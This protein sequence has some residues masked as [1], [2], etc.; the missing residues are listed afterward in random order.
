MI[1][2]GFISFMNYCCQCGSPVSARI[3]EGDD[4]PR[5]I[6][7]RCDT[8]HYQNP[9]MVVG[10]IPEWEDKIL[11]CKRS[12]EP[13]SGKWTLPAG[14]LEN[15]ET[16]VEGAKRETLEEAGARVEGL[17]PYALMSI[18][19]ISQIYLIF[20]AR[21]VDTNFAPGKESLE[22]RLYPESKIPWD[23]LAFLVVRETL[24]RYFNDRPAGAFPVQIG[25]IARP[26]NN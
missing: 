25:N 9:K 11:L 10:C 22:V 7:D 17:E 4:R 13:K 14:Y 6:C 16:V 8:V 19:H 24:K 1:Q 12:I 18:A 2:K 21:L 3:P 15:N 23:E 5:Y 26:V 20:R